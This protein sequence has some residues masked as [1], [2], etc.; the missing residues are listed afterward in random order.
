M[1]LKYS[2]ISSENDSQGL[3]ESILTNSLIR[4]RSE[5]RQI[6]LKTYKNNKNAQNCPV[7]QL[8]DNNRDLLE[9]CDKLRKDLDGF[10]IKL[11]V[12]ILTQNI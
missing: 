4:F 2:Q 10:G 12:S 9:L 8:K 6:V 5:V 7:Q 11:K 1:G 3:R